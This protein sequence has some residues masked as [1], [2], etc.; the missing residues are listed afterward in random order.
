MLDTMATE[1]NSEMEQKIQEIVSNRQRIEKRERT[2]FIAVLTVLILSLIHI[3][4]D[5]LVH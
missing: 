2:T 4:L 1:T 3:I 5:V